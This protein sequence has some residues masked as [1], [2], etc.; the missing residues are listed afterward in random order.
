MRRIMPTNTSTK[1]SPN[2][3]LLN[4]KC[5]CSM[6]FK[7]A[8]AFINA[9][10]G[11]SPRPEQIRFKLRFVKW[12][13]PKIASARPKPKSEPIFENGQWTS[14]WR[15][16]TGKAA[17]SNPNAR[18]SY[19]RKAKSRARLSMPD[20]EICFERRSATSFV[21]ALLMPMQAKRLLMSR[22]TRSKFAWESGGRASKSPMSA[23]ELR[24][25]RR[26]CS[27]EATAFATSTS[28][29]ARINQKGKASSRSRLSL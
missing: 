23:M 7:L 12:L 8:T 18:S 14:K 6:C 13:V 25:R 4:S 29:P 21:A 2:L 10:P 3:F 17:L 22:F 24:M 19:F 20:S 26:S 9:T 5:S 27:C 1:S 16:W 28:R 11:S 15:N